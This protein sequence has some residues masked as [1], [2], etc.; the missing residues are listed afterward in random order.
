MLKQIL[1]TLWLL[2]VD[3][4]L[5]IWQLPQNLLGILWLNV[6]II[7]Y[8]GV[9]HMTRIDDT[10]DWYEIPTKSGA[11]SL[12]KFII[13]HENAGYYSTIKHELGHC[14]QSLYL[15]WLYLIVI[16]IPSLIW[17]GVWQYTNK[18]YDWFYTERWANKLGNIN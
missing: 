16:A 1:Y 14:K 8:Y 13:S 4:F 12:G 7:C 5:F 6:N 10:I 9:N 11:V 3:V 18:P 15:G 17:C 2:W